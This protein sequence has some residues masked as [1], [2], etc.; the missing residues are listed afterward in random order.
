MMAIDFGDN[1]KRAMRR[2]RFSQRRVASAMGV[3]EVTVCRWVRGTTRP[4]YEN[5]VALS[6]LLGAT[7]GELLCPKEGKR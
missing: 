6:A 7:L 1:L 4:S 3:N 5:L 2:A